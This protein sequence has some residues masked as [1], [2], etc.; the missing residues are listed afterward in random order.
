[1]KNIYLLVSFVYLILIF[2]SC[3]ES[4]YYSEDEIHFSEIDFK[5]KKVLDGERFII[6]PE[7]RSM[8]LSNKKNRKFIDV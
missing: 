5:S 3:N 4:K 2:T 7:I 6:L 1:M 8:N